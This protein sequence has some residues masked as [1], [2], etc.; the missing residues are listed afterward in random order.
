MLS[1]GCRRLPVGRLAPPLAAGRSETPEQTLQ[2]IK[3]FVEESY[4]PREQWLQFYEE[5]FVNEE[6]K[7]GR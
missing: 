6:L 1:V 3:T 4:G 5:Q 7:R 2:W